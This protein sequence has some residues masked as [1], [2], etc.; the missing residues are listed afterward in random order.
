MKKK[1]IAIVLAAVM[2]MSVAGCEVKKKQ[3]SK[4]GRQQRTKKKL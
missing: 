1:V 4:K 3:K 2:A